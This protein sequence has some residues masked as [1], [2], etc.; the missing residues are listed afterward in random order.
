M[1]LEMIRMMNNEQLLA[2]FY[3]HT[4]R[5]TH[6]ANSKRGLTLKSAKE[7]SW[8]IH[9]MCQRFNLDPAELAQLLNPEN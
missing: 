1:K 5:T 2:H 3:W 8:I 4:V 6:E 7:E 9:E